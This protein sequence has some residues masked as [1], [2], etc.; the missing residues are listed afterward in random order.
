MR[1]HVGTSGYNYPEWKGAFYPADIK[2]KDMF[3][4]YAGRFHAVEI[5]YTF[6]RMP[7]TKTTSGWLAQAPPGFQYVLKAPR[8]ITHE[9]RLKAEARDALGA[10]CEAARVLGAHLGPLL[11]QLP[12]TFRR[13]LERLAGFLSMLPRDVRTAFEFRHESWHEPAVFDLLRAHGAALCVADVGDRTTPIEAT[14]R[15]GYVRLRDEGYDAPALERWIDD[16]AAHA[17]DW[18]DVYVFFKH[19]EAGRGAEFARDFSARLEARGLGRASPS[20]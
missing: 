3:A 9:R 15:H 13:D 18:D 2:T 19:E 6:Y 7:T 1:F 5:N 12:P 10:F 8:R 14:A 17:G 20:R 16:L 4:Y 11:F